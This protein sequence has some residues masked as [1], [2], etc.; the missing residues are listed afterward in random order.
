MQQSGFTNLTGIDPFING[1]YNFGDTF[2]IYKKNVFD[3]KNTKYDYIMLHHSFEH[4]ESPGLVMIKLR[5]LLNENGRI[6]IRVPVVSQ[7]FLDL[8]G[9]SLVSL[10]A[11]RHFYIHSVESMRLLCSA[12]NLQLIEIEYDSDDFVFWASEQYKNDICL[13]APNSYA[14]SRSQSMFSKK[15]IK[16]YRTRI[17][18]LNAKGLSD[19]AAFYLK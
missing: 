4:M 17:K 15:E 3:L 5:E 2:R 7:Y 11:P 19:N 1:D 12:A 9:T 13:S 6:L 14:K 10:D 18:E 8:Y 16:K